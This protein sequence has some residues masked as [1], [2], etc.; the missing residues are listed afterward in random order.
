MKSQRH[1]ALSCAGLP[2]CLASESARQGKEGPQENA[3]SF[4]QSLRDLSGR[5]SCPGALLVLKRPDGT[6][7]LSPVR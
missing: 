3:L 1:V 4:S 7:V 2:I 6:A 5:C